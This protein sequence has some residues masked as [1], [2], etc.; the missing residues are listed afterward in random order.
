MSNDT[1]V[2][3]LDNPIDK[4][5]GL[6][7]DVSSINLSPPKIGQLKYAANIKSAFYKAVMIQNNQPKKEDANV[8]EKK[9]SFN[10]DENKADDSE[11]KEEMAKA[12]LSVFAAFSE[13]YGEILSETFKVLLCQGGATVG[14]DKNPFGPRVWSKLSFKDVENLFGS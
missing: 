6:D 1:V 8:I 11:N 14:I 9:L 2:V 4:S 10:E 5:E 7:F 13:N 12:F 3:E